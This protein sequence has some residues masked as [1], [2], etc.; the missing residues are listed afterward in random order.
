MKQ[1]DGG[2]T[3]L[4]VEEL[5]RKAAAHRDEVTELEK[6]AAGLVTFAHA[7]WGALCAKYS[8]DVK[9][10]PA[11]VLAAWD[12]NGDGRVTKMEFRQVCSSPIRQC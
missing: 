11:K 7:L 9:P 10:D 2:Q 3:L 12:K 4:S 6:A 8:V 5:E 1:G